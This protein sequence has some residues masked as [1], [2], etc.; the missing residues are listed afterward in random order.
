VPDA[1]AAHTRFDVDVAA[2]CTYSPAAQ[3]VSAAHTR[4]C[5]ALGVVVWYSL[6][7]HAVHAVQLVAF[8][9]VE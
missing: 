9:V 5:V 1:H 7:V 6:A 3:V 2:V 8:V 4:F